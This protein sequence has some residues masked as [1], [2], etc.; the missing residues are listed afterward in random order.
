MAGRHLGQD[1][2]S[3]TFNI[4]LPH[5][6]SHHFKPKLSRAYAEGRESGDPTNQHAAGSAADACHIAG[7]FNAASAPHQLETAVP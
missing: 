6:T 1:F 3:G 5:L 7:A 2:A 4:A